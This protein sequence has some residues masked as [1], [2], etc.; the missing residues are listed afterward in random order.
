[1]GIK[2]RRRETKQLTDIER[3]ISEHLL[4]LVPGCEKLEFR[5][6]IG[7]NSVSVEFFSTEGGKRTQGYDM[8]DAGL[9][10]EK[11]F[12]IVVK[13]IAKLVRSSPEYKKGKINR[14]QFNVS[15]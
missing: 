13:D 8:I 9:I 6:N 5:A 7:D 14:I 2:Q 10:S 12:D 3:N 1:M 11:A 4:Q 15:L